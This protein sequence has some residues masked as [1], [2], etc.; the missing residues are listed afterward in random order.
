MSS[1]PSRPAERSKEA[2]GNF[3]AMSCGRKEGERSADQSFGPKPKKTDLA[4]DGHGFTRIKKAVLINL[5]RVNPCPSVAQLFP[6]R[7]A[8]PN[9]LA[10]SKL[11][12]DIRSPDH[13]S[14]PAGKEGEI[15]SQAATVTRLELKSPTIPN[16]SIDTEARI[17]GPQVAPDSYSELKSYV[18]IRSSENEDGTL[19]SAANP[20]ARGSVI[21]IY[22]T[23]EGQTS[24]AGV[25]GS[26]TQSNSQIPLLP[27][28]VM[29]GGMAAAV[30]FAGSAPQEVPGVLQV[31]TVVP[32]GIGSG[33]AVPVTVS[34]GGVASQT[35]VTMAVK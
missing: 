35:G 14:N 8:Q 10:H 18:S 22:A 30:P 26:V 27:V 11:R 7:W 23:G 17:F 3:A 24:P 28:T 15:P 19:N 33:S 31:N 12:G 29:I 25:T 4:T 2:N 9:S 16:Q 20:A 34:V 1:S 21:S 13:S 5:I 32:Q 6:R